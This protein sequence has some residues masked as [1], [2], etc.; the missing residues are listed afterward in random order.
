MRGIYKFTNLKNGKTY[1]RKSI[2]L[3]ARYKAHKRN[4]LN[5][6]LTDY[7]TKF[8]RALRKYG[9]DSF[10]YEILESSMQFSNQELNEKE[11]Y[12]IKLYNAINNGYNIQQGGENT[13]VSRKLTNEQII[14]IK[15]LIKNNEIT[16]QEIAMQFNVSDGLISMIN[17]GTAWSS[18]GSYIYPIRS[19][20]QNHKGG[21][22]GRAKFS[23]EEVLALR[24]YF[25]DHILDEVCEK[26]GAN[27]SFSEMK[28]I[29]YGVQF[30]HLP[31]Y[32]KRLKKWILN[33]TCIDYPR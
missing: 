30:T 23:D 16:F 2:N 29:C 22:N 21:K 6:N 20:T 28:K 18:I 12:Y 4:H 14:E 32:K 1:I 15:E 25:V 11:K 13:G 24:E 26:F 5:P 19:I 17:S 9:F 10:S 27:H 3:E 31:I 8:Y 7:N 33:G